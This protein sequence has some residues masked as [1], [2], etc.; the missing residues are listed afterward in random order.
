MAGRRRP[1]RSTRHAAPT[2]AGYSGVSSGG[3]R[4]RG[5]LK[6]DQVGWSR[7]RRWPRPAVVTCRARQADSFPGSDRPA[8][9]APVRSA[10]RRGGRPGRPA[11]RLESHRR[12]RTA[13]GIM[14]L[15]RRYARIDRPRRASTAAGHRLSPPIPAPR[16]R[17][18]EWRAGG[19]ARG[20][21][22]ADAR[23][24]ATSTPVAFK[25]SRD[26]AVAIWQGTR[27]RAAPQDDGR[28]RIRGVSPVARRARPRALIGHIVRRPGCA[29]KGL[30]SD[31]DE[32]ARTPALPVSGTTR[33]SPP[34]PGGRR[35]RRPARLRGPG[36][37]PGYVLGFRSKSTASDCVVKPQ[38]HCNP[39]LSRRLRPRPP[40]P[41]TP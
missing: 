34:G 15:P 1:A 29:V 35:A 33:P 22:R 4:P 25:P 5:G 2:S 28:V 12:P 3:R 16:E 11:T 27:L 40:R 41:H 30:R 26:L 17:P 19:D 14:A 18:T 32:L 7:L 36:R 31:V 38:L 39:R 6:V 8:C 20:N 23:R 9:F 21:S 24:S 37:Y 13:R 10:Q